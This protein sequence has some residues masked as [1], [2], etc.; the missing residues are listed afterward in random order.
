MKCNNCGARLDDNAKVCSNCGAHIDNNDEYVLLTADEKMFDIYADAP[1][2]ERDR[3]LKRKNNKKSRIIWFISIII[4]LAIIGGGAYY[5]FANIYSPKTNQPELSFEGGAGIINDDEKVVYVLLSQ[6]SK[7]EFIHGVSIYDYDKTDKS[8]ENKDPVSSDYEY[9]KSIDS[10]FR[11]IFFDLKDLKPKKGDNTYTFEMKFSFYNSDEIY[12]YTQPVS[13]TSPAKSNVADLV[14]DHST[15]E[16]TTA[17]DSGDSAE[18]ETTKAEKTTALSADDYSFIYDYY[19]YTEPIQNG[20]EYS[21]S[22]LKLNNDNTYVST[23]YFKEG[24]GGWQITRGNG[25]YKI[26]D[27]YVVIDNGVATESSYYKIDAQNNSLFEEEN[28]QKTSTLEA[29]KYNSI[30]NAEDFFGI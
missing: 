3:A 12:T 2:D 5:Y 17:S 30:K 8:A 9:T 24:D 27:G 15:E 19:W 18:E 10:T 14:F 21:I 4:T 11:A 29:R 23:S 28:G 16:E 26:E 1:E 22:A 13:F 25:S 7:I 20:E 6:D